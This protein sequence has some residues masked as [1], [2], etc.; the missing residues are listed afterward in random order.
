LIYLILYNPE[1]P[2]IKIAGLD[3]E[4]NKEKIMVDRVLK[5]LIQRILESCSPCTW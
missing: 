4:F 1:S 2:G 5:A 3:E